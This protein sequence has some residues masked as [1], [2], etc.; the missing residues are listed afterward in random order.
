MPDHSEIRSEFG[1]PDIDRLRRRAFAILSEAKLTDR[2]DRHDFASFIL[3]RKVRTW[4]DLTRPEWVRLVDALCG[5]V[6]VRTLRQQH[7][8]E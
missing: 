2:A 6:A 3:G 1:E 7:G 5:W 8:F 4:S